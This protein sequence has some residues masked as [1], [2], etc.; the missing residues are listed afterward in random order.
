ML[1]T[2]N[3][4]LERLERKEPAAAQTA[5]EEPDVAGAVAAVASYRGGRPGGASTFAPRAHAGSAKEQLRRRKTTPFPPRRDQLAFDDF[6]GDR[7]S[8]D[9]DAG[10]STTAGDITG[11]GR[12]A[13][14]L[15]ANMRANHRSALDYVRATD[16]SNLRAAHEAR[17]T[18]QAID[19]LLR[20]GVPLSFEG[21]EILLRNL[22]GVVEADRLG[23]PAVLTGMEWQPPQDIVPRSVL[24]TVLKDAKRIKEMKP[25]RPTKPTP[26]PR[27]PKKGGQQGAGKQ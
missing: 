26:A 22:A 8:G 5:D 3:A 13:E 19:A 25:K 24:R 6:A 16:F 1:Q 14:V 9:D 12:L 21:M 15:M 18:A 20:E 10:G 7:D 23:E 27:D 4:R 11:D 2:M 17:R